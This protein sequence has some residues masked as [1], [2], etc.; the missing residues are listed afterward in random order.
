MIILILLKGVVIPQ[1]KYYF[2]DE[3]SC[4]QQGVCTNLC[5]DFS[6]KEP[7]LK[8]IR[9]FNTTTH[10]VLCEKWLAMNETNEG[11]FK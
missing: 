11:C 3:M 4:L 8:L 6:E 10:K 5:D 1:Y 2:P 9:C 7:P